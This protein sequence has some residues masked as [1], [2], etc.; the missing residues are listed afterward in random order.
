MRYV[1][2]VKLIDDSTCLDIL[3][4]YEK[5]KI[6]VIKKIIDVNGS[7]LDNYTKKSIIAFSSLINRADIADFIDKNYLYY[8]NSVLMTKWIPFCI[9]H[10]KG[11]KAIELLVQNNV[12]G[13]KVFRSTIDISKDDILNE[14][15]YIAKYKND[16]CEYIRSGT[17]I[18]SIEVLYWSIEIAGKFHFGNDYDFFSRYSKYLGIKLSNQLTFSSQDGRTLIKLEKGI[19]FVYNIEIKKISTKNNLSKVKHTRI[20][21]QY[22]LFLLLGDSMVGFINENKLTKVVKILSGKIEVI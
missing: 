22:A 17:I 14:P 18:P 16:I 8:Y 3:N 9:E 4:N 13:R 19:G 15:S 10:I 11:E 7:L 6:N 21:S 2:G 1:N 20:N 12:F 5:L